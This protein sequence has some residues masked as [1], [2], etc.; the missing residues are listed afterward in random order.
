MSRSK[1]YEYFALN[2]L[3]IF[4]YHKYFIYFGT[5]K[6]STNVYLSFSI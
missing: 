6:Y 3:D 1:Y 4:V 5:F 2:I